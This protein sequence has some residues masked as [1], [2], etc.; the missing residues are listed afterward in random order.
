MTEKDSGFAEVL[1]SE[2]SRPAPWANDMADSMVLEICVKEKDIRWSFWCGPVGEC[3]EPP[4]DLEQEQIICSRELCAIRKATPGIIL[5]LVETA[6]KLRTF[7]DY[8]AR[9]FHHS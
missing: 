9:I 4:W 5:A 3:K 6:S 7:S 2:A 1:D 8:V